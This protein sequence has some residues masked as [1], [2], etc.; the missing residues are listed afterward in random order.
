MTDIMKKIGEIG[1]VPLI[2]LDD[3]ND[4]VPLAKA[5]VAGGIPVA[6]LTFRTSAA[7]ESLKKISKEV[8]EILLGAG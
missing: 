7:L 5:L 8:P 2:V 1:F 6:E 3:A 4:A